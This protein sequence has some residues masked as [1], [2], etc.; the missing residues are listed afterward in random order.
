MGPDRDG[1]GRVLWMFVASAE[2][3]DSGLTRLDIQDPEAVVFLRPPLSIF[4]CVH[5]RSQLISY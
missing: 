4:I 1:V 3:S 5:N 2:L